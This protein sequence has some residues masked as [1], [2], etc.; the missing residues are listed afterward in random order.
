MELVQVDGLGDLLEVLPEK[1]LV[2]VEDVVMDIKDMNVPSTYEM[3]VSYQVYTPIEFGENFRLVYS[4][5]EEGIGADLEDINK[6]D[7]KGIR[8]EA[9]AVTNIPM[10]LTLSVDALDRNN[11]SL[12][13]KVISVNDIVINAHTGEGA[14]S[15]Q[16]IS[17]TILPKEGHT[18]REM[19]EKMD[20]FHYRAVADADAN[21]VLKE[22]AS[23]RLTN[24]KITLLG[25]I[26]YDAN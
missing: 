22:S 25:G 17:L 16:A 3:G 1:I 20:K 21:D 2:D 24:I 11:V 4:G 6:M 13:G 23:I 12:K 7:T 14:A 15:T 10:N 19:L 5:T 8:I 26:A 9:N 18:I